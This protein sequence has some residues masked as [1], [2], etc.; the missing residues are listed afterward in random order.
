MLNNRNICFKLYIVCIFVC[1][2]VVYDNSIENLFNY[3]NWNLPYVADFSQENC[4]ILWNENSFCCIR[5]RQ[6]SLASL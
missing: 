2:Y 3:I 4:L 6:I 5:L 1:T